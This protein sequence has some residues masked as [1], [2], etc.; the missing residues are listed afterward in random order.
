[1]FAEKSLNYTSVRTLVKGTKAAISSLRSQRG[2]FLQHLEE[3]L[4]RLAEYGVQQPTDAQLN[5]FR[6]QIEQHY[7]TNGVQHL[8]QRL[9]H[10]GIISA[11]DVFAG[12]DFPDDQELISTHEDKDISTLAKHFSPN[13][14]NYSELLVEWP[15]FCYAVCMADSRNC[16][17]TLKRLKQLNAT[18]VTEQLIT[19]QALRELYPNLSSLACIGLVIPTSTVDCEKGFSTVGRIKTQKRNRLSFPVLER[20]LYI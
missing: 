1:M 2:T 10:S 15:A 17:D 13:I 16:T 11:F 4:P 5:S 19:V 20:L 18:E 6:L 9:P 14:I 3:E 12:N 7:L 8:E